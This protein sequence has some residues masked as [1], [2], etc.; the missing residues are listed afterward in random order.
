MVGIN[1]GCLITFRPS[2]LL[3]TAVESAL[4]RYD[5]GFILYSG[6]SSHL[7]LK[8]EDTDIHVSSCETPR[9]RVEPTSIQQN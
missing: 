3:V 8:I 1:L 7:S 5:M 6:N 9:S 4:Y 2:Q